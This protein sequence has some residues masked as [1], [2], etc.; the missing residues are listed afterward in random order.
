MRRLVAYAVNKEDLC[1][2][3][4][5]YSQT[6]Q[7]LDNKGRAVVRSMRAFHKY[8]TGYG[9]EILMEYLNAFVDAGAPS[10]KSTVHA[11]SKNIFTHSMK[12]I[13]NRNM[14]LVGDAAHCPNPSFFHVRNL[15]HWT[16]TN[17]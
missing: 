12:N 13:V 8:T 15:F 11:I 9:A 10:A 14:A 7:A 17:V 2:E 1:I 5:V 3:S 6:E 16:T 4:Y